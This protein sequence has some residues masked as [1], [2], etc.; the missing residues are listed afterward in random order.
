MANIADLLQD[1]WHK[2]TG[3][4]LGTSGEELRINL[5]KVWDSKTQRI[6]IYTSFGKR[7][8]GRLIN[9][10]SHM[11]NMGDTTLKDSEMYVKPDKAYS[12]QYC[13]AWK[14]EEANPSSIG[15]DTRDVVK[16]YLIR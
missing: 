2:I 4:H 15:V 16:A 10:D 5:S 3:S 1:A 7:V 12:P 11:F 8:E 13:S 6:A 14:T 9:F